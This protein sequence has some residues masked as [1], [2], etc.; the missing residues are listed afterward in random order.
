MPPPFLYHGSPTGGLAALNPER[1]SGRRAD[2][3]PVVF[4]TADLPFATMFMSPRRH[5]D[6]T[7][8]GAHNGVWFEVVSDR[9][10]FLTEDTGGVVYKLSGSGFYQPEGYGMRTEWVSKEPAPVL[11]E[12]HFP[13]SL[14][15][16]VEHGVQVYFVDA[17]TFARIDASDDHGYAIMQMLE[18]E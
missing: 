11:E 9:A 14:R 18:P 13:S 3:G 16:M 10:R 6:W 2:E 8:K 17:E 5:D 15:A 12:L 4:A 1:R 7:R